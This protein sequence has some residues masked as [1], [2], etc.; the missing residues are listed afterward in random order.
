GLSSARQDLFGF[1]NAMPGTPRKIHIGRDASSDL[2]LTDRSVSRKHAE[3]LIDSTGAM[4]LLD[5]D[6]S[7]G[8]FLIRAGKED[9][10]SRAKLKTGDVI[11][12]GEVELSLADLQAR[13][14]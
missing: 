11:R 4:E 8:T 7:S 1:R 9:E 10:I 12:F 5:L 6:S 2:V 14:E 3:L 13:V